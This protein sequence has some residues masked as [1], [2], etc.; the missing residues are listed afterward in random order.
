M[1]SLPPP[2]GAGGPG[3]WHNGNGSSKGSRHA[4]SSSSR[5]PLARCRGVGAITGP[6]S[7]L[8][9]MLGGGLC[10]ASAAAAPGAGGGGAEAAVSQWVWGVWSHAHTYTHARMQACMLAFKRLAARLLRFLWRVCMRHVHARAHPRAPTHTWAHPHTPVHTRAHPRLEHTYPA[11]SMPPCKHALPS[12]RAL[13]R[14]DALRTRASWRFL[15]DEK[16]RVTDVMLLLNCTCFALQW[17]SKDMLTLWGAKVCCRCCWCC[18]CWCCCCCWL[19]LCMHH[20]VL[21]TLLVPARRIHPHLRSDQRAHLCG[22]VVAAHQRKLP[23]L[24]PAPLGGASAGPLLLA[25]GGGGGCCSEARR[26]SSAHGECHGGAA[27]TTVKAAPPRTDQLPCAQHRGAAH[28]DDCGGPAHG[29]RV[30]GSRGGW[31]R[32]QLF[33]DPSTVCG[34]LRCVMS[35]AIWWW[36][37]PRLGARS[38]GQVATPLKAI[39]ARLA[40]MAVYAA[41]TRSVAQTRVGAAAQQHPRQLVPTPTHA[42]RL[43][44]VPPSGWTWRSLPSISWCSNSRR[45]FI[46]ALGRP[47]PFPTAPWLQPPPRVAALMR[48]VQ[49]G[50]GPSPSHC[51]LVQPLLNGPLIAALRRPLW[52]GRGA[53][54]LL[55]PPQ[56]PAEGAQRWRAARPG[57]HARH[58]PWL[59]AARQ[60]HRQLVGGAA[61]P[62][63]RR[64]R[65][66]WARWI[67]AL[68]H[69]AQGGCAARPAHRTPTP[70]SGTNRE[71]PCGKTCLRAAG[72]LLSNTHLS[73]PTPRSI[74]LH[75]G[76]LGGLLGGALVSGVLGPSYVRSE[77]GMISDRPP[78]RLMAF[79]DREPSLGMVSGACA[80][81]VCNFHA[82]VHNNGSFNRPEG[83][84]SPHSAL[85]S[86]PISWW[87]SLIIC[88]PARGIIRLAAKLGHG[89]PHLLLVLCDAACCSPCRV[90]TRLSTGPRSIHRPSLCTPLHRSYFLTHVISS[91]PS[92]SLAGQGAQ[93][94][95]VW[96]RDQ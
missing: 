77:T 46:A 44:P 85:L 3:P 88:L 37:M 96:T 15:Q 24:Q 14:M 94:A 10:M 34:R 51:S 89:A 1:A 22:P 36:V 84:Q 59:L 61:A 5:H 54:H 91:S 64:L 60:E 48:P 76:H 86:P 68:G 63:C 79:P 95:F 53:C 62:C 38:A 42:S 80:A 26:H 30:P 8:G 17:L 93:Q 81:L 83:L 7:Q 82:L 4:S 50:R 29:G 78:L 47:S 19:L 74:S 73:P 70:H 58:Q 90:Q 43:P 57:H 9:A 16:R 39:N 2:A 41:A 65:S 67:T 35:T 72:L 13:R 55:L 92:L 12:G 69:W 27:P 87:L 23:A 6:A 31:Q 33:H 40:L 49:A 21:V 11:P 18:C 20:V 75:R 71:R 28:R 32:G 25:V 45:Q 56:A 52:A 66:E